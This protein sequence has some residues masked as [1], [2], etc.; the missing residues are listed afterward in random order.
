MPRS[1]TGWN[2]AL[3]WRSS[4]TVATLADSSSLTRPATAIRAGS[5]VV[6]W[7][8]PWRFDQYS[9]ASAW[10][11]NSDRVVPNRGDSEI[12]AENEIVR[13]TASLPGAGSRAIARSRRAT[14]S[15]P[16]T[17]VA[18]M[19]IANSSPPTRNARSLRRIQPSM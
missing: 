17:S 11:N 15:A 6:T 13:I 14:T 5:K 1:T 18:G 10:A 2:T 4:T 16:S 7:V 3:S 19:M 12:P 9:A 8:R